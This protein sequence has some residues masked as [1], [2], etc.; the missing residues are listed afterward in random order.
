MRSRTT[1]TFWKLHDALGRILGEPKS[2]QD[3]HCMI[4]GVCV[5]VH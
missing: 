4:D 3:L 2:T 5:R 1:K